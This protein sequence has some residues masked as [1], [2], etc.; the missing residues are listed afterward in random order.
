MADS[1]ITHDPEILGGTP[2]ISG[3]RISVQ[4]IMELVANGGTIDEIIRTYPR[5]ERKDVEAALRFAREH[6]TSA[7][8]SPPAQ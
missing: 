6:P 3:T 2:C 5:L 4:F 8:A 7:P 1:R